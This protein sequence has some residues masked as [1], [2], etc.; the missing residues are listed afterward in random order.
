M[1]N[2]LP[3]TMR[4]WRSETPG[5]RDLE[6]ADLPLPKPR[7][8]E[9]LVRISAAALNF[10]DLLMIDDRY[11]VRPPRPFAPGQE[12]AGTVI[13]AGENSGLA[14]GDVIASKVH[15]GGF[16]EYAV[17]RGDM[18]IRVP[19]GTSLA[20]AAALPV[21]YT[22]A[23][24]ALTESTTIRSGDVVLVLAAAGGVGLACVE[25]ANQLGAQVIAAAG[26]E[27]KCALAR[28]HGALEAVDY[29]QENWSNVLKSLTKGQGVDVIVDPVGGPATLEALRALAWEGR[30]LVVGFSSGEIPR[31]PANRL[32]LKRASA[33]GVYWS[34]DRDATML[35]RV[36]SKLTS[37]LTTG[38]IR[39]HIG[40]RFPFNQ[41]PQALASL[42]ERRSTGK[43]LLIAPDEEME[44]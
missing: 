23:I 43:V 12:I 31:I 25:V 17:V 15:W 37:L 28:Q 35:K 20:A 32:L 24:V 11:Q 4:C 1:R 33:I 38:A 9:A 36:A 18:A 44:S 42:A 34:H 8:D 40:A 29:R 7:D 2:D 21:V 13:V 22:T 5:L 26:G 19:S 30:L 27:D 10:S 39:P 14:T 6:L 16:A 3:D 41:L